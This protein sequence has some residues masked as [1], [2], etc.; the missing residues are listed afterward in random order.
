MPYSKLHKRVLD[1]V[2]IDWRNGHLLLEFLPPA[3][4]RA[5]GLTRVEVVRAGDAADVVADVKAAAGSVKVVMASG[6]F[7]HAEAESFDVTE[8]A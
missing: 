1:R 2:T 6:G 4:V 8:E 3:M 5:T 7:V